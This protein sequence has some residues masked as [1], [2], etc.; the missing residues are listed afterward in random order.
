MPDHGGGGG[1]HPR[2]VGQ[3][4][5]HDDPVLAA[6]LADQVLEFGSDDSAG[7]CHYDLLQST[8]EE[9]A[10]LLAEADLGH[11]YATRVLNPCLMQNF[12]HRADV[13]CSILLRC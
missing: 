6:E 2:L 12:V 9:L 1:R 8:Q 5:H 13:P 3:G 10:L 11:R 7:G 4:L